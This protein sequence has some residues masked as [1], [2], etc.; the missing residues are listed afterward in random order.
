[1]GNG[2]CSYLASWEQKEVLRPKSCTVWVR[3]TFEYELTLQLLKYVLYRMNMGSINEIRYDVTVTW[4]PSSVSC[5]ASLPFINPLLNA[6]K[7][8][9]NVYFRISPEV[10]HHLGTF[11]LLFFLILWIQTCSFAVLF[12]I[13]YVVGKYSIS[14]TLLSLKLERFSGGIIRDFCTWMFS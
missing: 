1:M 4:P 10:V 14:D 13:Y 2:K 3:T 11:R 5:I 7:C 8:A 6:I 9:S 12:F